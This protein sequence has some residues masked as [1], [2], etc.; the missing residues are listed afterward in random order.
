[1]RRSN[2]PA[3][4]VGSLSSS[5]VDAIPTNRQKHR[6]SVLTHLLALAVTAWLLKGCVSPT[7]VNDNLAKAQ[8]LSRSL[9]RGTDFTHV[10]YT[11][12][13]GEGSVWH[14]YLEGDGRPWWG[15]HAV[16]PDPTTVRP[17]MLRLMQQDAA[18]RLYLG[19]PCYLGMAA[20]TACKPWV[21]TH[22]RYSQQVV[23]SLQAVIEKLI[24]RHAIEQLVLFGHSGGGALAM[25]LAERIPQTRKLVT[26]AGNLDTQA[27]TKKHGYSDLSGSM[28]PSARAALPVRI[29]QFHFRGIKDRNLPAAGPG[30]IS[31]EEVGHA[32]GWER[33]FCKLLVRTGGSCRTTT[34]TP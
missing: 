7:K 12:S 21:W 23:S 34:L 17:L 15:R 18:P 25:L 1:M 3:T 19:R 16:A 4:A 20:E 2:S 22:G 13:K 5:R 8:G 26:L 14:L 6:L 9:I 33:V 30:I 32:Q 11:D 24:E 10:V 28:N 27:W 29:Q 31:V